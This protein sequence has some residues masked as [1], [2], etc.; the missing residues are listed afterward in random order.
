[1]KLKVTKSLGSFIGVV[2]KNIYGDLGKMRGAK[3]K[4][5]NKN[6]SNAV[7]TG[8]THEVSL[9]NANIS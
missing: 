3:L 9:K 5:L 2:I 8:H 6:Q 4:Q 1:V 7:Y